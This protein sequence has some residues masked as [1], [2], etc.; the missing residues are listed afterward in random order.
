MLQHDA[1]QEIIDNQIQPQLNVGYSQTAWS[2]I[3]VDGHPGTGCE[4]CRRLTDA[5][6]HIYQ[7][8]GRHYETTCEF[9]QR[10]RY[11][12]MTPLFLTLYTWHINFS[13][14]LHDLRT[15]H[16][17]SYHSHNTLLSRIHLPHIYCKC[18]YI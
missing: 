16:H 15:T 10:R 6:I 18:T 7:E 3:P 2:A 14:F 11:G 1:Q 8:M 5:R 17:P 13:S 4:R 12:I 9:W